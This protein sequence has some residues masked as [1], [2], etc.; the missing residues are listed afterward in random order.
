MSLQLNHI[1]G[2][3]PT[4]IVSFN[5]FAWPNAQ[6]KGVCCC[7]RKR[8]RTWYGFASA[9]SSD[10]FYATLTGGSVSL[11]PPDAERRTFATRDEAQ[12]FLDELRRA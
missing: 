5:T 7:A 12:H 9:S 10:E 6:P 4:H 11:F 8:G 1:A 3:A 2:A